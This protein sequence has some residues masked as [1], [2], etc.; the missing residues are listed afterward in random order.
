MIEQ[1]PL[2]EPLDAFLR[3]VVRALAVA[4]TRGIE[5]VGKDPQT[6]DKT[7]ADCKE[8]LDTI[9]AGRVEEWIAA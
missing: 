2:T 4:T 8:I 3:E 9:M 5:S 6:T 7:L 1:V